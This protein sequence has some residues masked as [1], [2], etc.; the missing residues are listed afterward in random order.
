MLIIVKLQEEFFY[1]GPKFLKP[2]TMKEVA[3]EIGLS[4]STISR[5]SSSKYIQTEWGIHEIKYFFTNAVSK[6][7]PNNQSAES[8]REIIKEIYEGEKD[9]K[10]SDQKIVDILQNR[11]IKIARRTVAKYRKILNILPSHHRK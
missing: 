7:S 11:G 5:L 2:L 10:I 8:I 6:D 3:E 1:K 4:E 9:K